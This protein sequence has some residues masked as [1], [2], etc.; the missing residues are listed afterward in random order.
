MR[1]RHQNAIKPLTSPSDFKSEQVGMSQT[2]L[3]SC[4][5]RCNAR[6]RGNKPSPWCFRSHWDGSLQWDAMECNA[7]QCNAVD[8]N[9][10]FCNRDPVRVL[11]M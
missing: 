4:L 5:A 10:M 11:R 7:M 3:S 2:I 6:V 9:A 1:E 8:Y